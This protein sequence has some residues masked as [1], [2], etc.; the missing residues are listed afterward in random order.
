MEPFKLDEYYEMMAD[1]VKMEAYQEALR[2]CAPGKVVLDL[3]GGPGP[4]TF[5]AVQ[6]GARK[7]YLVE[8]G[9]VIDLARRVALHLNMLDKITFIRGLSTE[10]ELPEKVDVIVS[11]TL[12]SLGIEE[13]TAEFIIDARERFLAPDG[14]LLPN[15][16]R[17]FLGLV[18][19]PGF[20]AEARFWRNAYGID[21]SPLLEYAAQRKRRTFIQPES[22]LTAP[23]LLCDLD[24][25]VLQQSTF[26]RFFTFVIQRSGLLNGFCSWFEAGF[27]DE[28]QISTSPE[29]PPTHWKQAVLPLSRPFVVSPGDEVFV[30]FDASPSS[31]RRD[32]LSI[33][34]KLALKRHT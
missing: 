5:M 16:L 20:E 34:F 17:V 30:W 23:Q 28:N 6:A 12:G 31:L 24:L 18:Q 3:G 4:L 2:V 33:Q 15:R 32:D 7:V 21:Y 10:I 26:S 19:D 29:Q 8:R 11:E 9:P 22:M 1:T 13:N 27:S 25:Y 14:I